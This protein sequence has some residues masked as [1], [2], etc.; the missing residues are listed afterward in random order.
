MIMDDYP[1]LGAHFTER[2]VDIRTLIVPV[3]AFLMARRARHDD[4]GSDRG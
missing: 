2:V 3:P 4:S 1:E